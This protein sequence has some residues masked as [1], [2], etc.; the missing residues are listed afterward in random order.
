MALDFPA[1]PSNGT[2]YAN[3]GS[4]DTYWTYDGSKWVGKVISGGGEGGGGLPEAPADNVAY[5]RQN[6]AWVPVLML[7]NDTLDGGNF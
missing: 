5:G 4:P 3:P 2:T 7:S 6:V 1:N